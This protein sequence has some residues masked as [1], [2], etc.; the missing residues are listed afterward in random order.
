MALP[1]RIRQLSPD[2]SAIAQLLAAQ[3]LK[4]IRTHEGDETA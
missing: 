3:S 4:F 2:V 1:L